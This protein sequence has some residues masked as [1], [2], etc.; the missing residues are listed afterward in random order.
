MVYEL[1]PPASWGPQTL[2]HSSLVRDGHLDKSDR[3][4]G[5]EFSWAAGRAWPRGRWHLILEGLC[6]SFTLQ[7]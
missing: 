7:A 4:L 2:G 6:F 3:R 5:A 1:C